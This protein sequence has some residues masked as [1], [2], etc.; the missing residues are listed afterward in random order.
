MNNKYEIYVDMDGVLCNFL[1]A[2]SKL[3][4]EKLRFHHDWEKIKH[5]AWRQIAEEGSK[6]WAY[7]PW[8]QDG[9]ELWEYVKPYKPNILSAY[10]QAS[11]NRWYAE[12]G[13]VQWI[14]TELTGYNNINIVRG[15][16][17]Q[18]YALKNAIL[19]DD[20]KRNI[21]QFTE[22]GGIGILHKNTKHTIFKLKVLGL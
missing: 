7:L 14:N 13:K 8:M 9:K 20:A 2:A 11:A 18:K 1:Q 21:D 15:Q 10:P 16:D 5:T 6:F 3:T 12:R 19:I 4:G 22:A 17:K